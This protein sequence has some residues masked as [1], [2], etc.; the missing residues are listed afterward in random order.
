M[1]TQTSIDLNQSCALMSP[2]R[3][4]TLVYILLHVISWTVGIEREAWTEVSFGERTYSLPRSYFDGRSD[5][6][7]GR[8]HPIWVRKEGTP[9]PPSRDHG[10]HMYSMNFHKGL[11]RHGQERDYWQVQKHEF[12]NAVEVE[13]KRREKKQLE[14]AHHSVR[15]GYRHL[16]TTT[17]TCCH[18]R[19]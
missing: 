19:R 5:E 13:N 10:D 15:E 1:L 2:L 14:G 16:S 3:L 6:A 8:Y 11:S 4:V 18:S 7:N 12:L 9:P 17:R